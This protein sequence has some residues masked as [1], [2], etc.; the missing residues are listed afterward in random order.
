MTTRQLN[1]LATA[2]PA[3][4]FRSVDPRWLFVPALR[5]SAPVISLGTT[6]EPDAFLGGRDVTSFDVPP[7]LTSVGWWRDGPPVGGQRMAVILGHSQEGGGYAAFNR[8][9]TLTPGAQVTVEDATGSTRVDFVVMKVVSGLSKADPTALN[10]ALAEGAA[11]A[12]LALV[13]CSG[14]FDRRYAENA[15]NTVVFARRT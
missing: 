7:D 1:P 4:D 9:P 14:E 8:L 13:T 12:Q 6:V 5:L 3:G 2:R 15:A 11:T 10:G